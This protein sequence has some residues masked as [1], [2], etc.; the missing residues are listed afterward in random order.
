MKI[1]IV[2]TA[3]IGDVILATPLVEKLHRHYP[4]ARLDVMLRRGNEGLLVGN[5][6]VGKLWIWDK[7]QGKYRSLFA[8]LKKIRRERYDIL[9]NLQRF[10][11]TGIFTALAGAKST[12][13][14]DKNPASF[15]F[16]KRVKHRIGSGMHEVQR[17]LQLIAHLTDA[18]LEMPKLYPQPADFE[19]VAAY[20]AKPYITISPTSVWFTKQ[21]PAEKWSE[22]IALTSNDLQVYLLGGKAD[23]EACEQLAQRANGRAIS[24][25]GELTFLQSAALMRDAAMN[26]VNDSAPQHLASAMNA[27]TLA[28]FC[29]T[30]PAFGFGPLAHH[31]RVVEADEALPCRP[32]GLHGYRACPKGHFR[33]ACGIDV[34]KMLSVT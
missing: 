7:K 24:L 6:H 21:L 27:P 4:S 10:A 30:V 22:L 13:G 8:L 26:Y 33:C 31:S 14:F 9:I 15:L 28:V 2:Q 12:V 29:S 32:C 20:K 34:R 11:S 16:G 25:A 19:R 23:R 3:F 1:L 18:E 17:N 5:P